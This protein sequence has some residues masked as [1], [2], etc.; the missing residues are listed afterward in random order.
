MW[1]WGVLTAFRLH[2]AR[3]SAHR[4]RLGRGFRK[5]NCPIHAE[6]KCGSEFI[7]QGLKTANWQLAQKRIAEAEARGQWLPDQQ[8]IETSVDIAIE[9]FRRDAVARALAPATLKKYRVLTAQLSEY[10]SARGI[11]FLNEFDLDTR[12]ETFANPSFSPDGRW[13]AYSSG[14]A[15]RPHRDCVSRGGNQIA[16]CA[17][18][19]ARGCVPRK[20]LRLLTTACSRRQITPSLDGLGRAASDAQPLD[21]VVRMR[22]LFT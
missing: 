5:C 14:A 9:K 21:A 12:C 15:A 2:T 6:G 1:D 18:T 3:C 7:R 17:G 10:A 4:P 11:R 13:L 8:F 20:L 16:G 19:R 22:T